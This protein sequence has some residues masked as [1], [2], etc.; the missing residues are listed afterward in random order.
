MGSTGYIVQ[1]WTN[2]DAETG[3]IIQDSVKPIQVM[4]EKNATYPAFAMIHF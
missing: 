4:S 2:T 1:G 3:A